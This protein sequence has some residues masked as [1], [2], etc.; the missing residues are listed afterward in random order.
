MKK[1][2]PTILAIC[3]VVGLLWLGWELLTFIVGWVSAISSVQKPV[4]I[5]AVALL[6]VPIVTYFTT[7]LIERRRSIDAITFAKRVEIYDKF[8]RFFMSSVMNKE[9]MPENIP[10]KSVDPLTFMYEITPEL[11][12][13]ASNGVIKE[14]GRFRSDAAQLPSKGNEKAVMVKVEGLL[15]AM[16]KDLGHSSLSMQDGDIARLFI[17]DIDQVLG[18]SK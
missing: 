14:W 15:K 9:N 13:Y 10:S 3:V 4:L 1:L 8:V 18:K 7:R 16:R 12:I 11:L 6:L 2:W 5:S 17:N